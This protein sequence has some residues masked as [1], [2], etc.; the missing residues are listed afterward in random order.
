ME[1]HGYVDATLEAA[2]R[3]ATR[4]YPKV[5]L[6]LQAYLRRTADDLDRLPAGMRVRLVKG[7]YLEPTDVV[8]ADKRE[9]DAQL[10]AAV[11][12]AA[13]ARPPD[14]RRHARPVADRGRASPG[15]RGWRTAGHG[16]SSRC[17]TVC[18]GTSRPRWH[19]RGIPSACTSRTAR[20]GTRT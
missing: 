8:F 17:C 7:A 1:S 16:W 15:R 4:R 19:G 20:S 18:A 13:R 5:G 12:D 10:R 14:R 6:A 2:G 11:H 9:V 3:R